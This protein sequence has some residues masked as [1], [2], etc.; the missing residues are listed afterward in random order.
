MAEAAHAL[1]H[2]SSIQ[3]VLPDACP[4]RVE[5]RKPQCPESGSRNLG[6]SVRVASLRYTGAF[7]QVGKC[8]AI[9]MKPCDFF[10]KQQL[11]PQPRTRRKHYTSTPVGRATPTRY[12]R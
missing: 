7:L 8:V 2:Q 3:L 12:N 1:T 6:S 4:R 5:R 11:N 10:V 9:R